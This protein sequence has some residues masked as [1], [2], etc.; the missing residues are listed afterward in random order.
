MRLYQLK[1]EK[2]A[3][4]PRNQSTDPPQNRPEEPRNAAVDWREA[5]QRGRKDD[6]RVE[7]GACMFP[8]RQP[9][10]PTLSD[11]RS[12]LSLSRTRIASLIPTPSATSTSTTN[13]RSTKLTRAFI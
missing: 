12:S 1:K 5:S 10:L 7:E 6:L 4:Q 8:F 3:E 2:T 13:A 11:L 9:L